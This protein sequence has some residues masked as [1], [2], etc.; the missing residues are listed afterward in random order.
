MS[1]QPGGV[2]QVSLSYCGLGIFNDSASAKR[3]E[4]SFNVCHQGLMTVGYVG[5]HPRVLEP[6]KGNKWGMDLANCLQ[7]GLERFLA[8]ILKLG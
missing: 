6:C 8:M 1:E 2:S 5:C 3:K 7:R 4:P